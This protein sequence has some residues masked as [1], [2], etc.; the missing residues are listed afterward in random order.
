MKVIVCNKRLH[1]YG[2]MSFAVIFS[3]L[4]DYS[5]GGFNEA[6]PGNWTAI[7]VFIGEG[8]QEAEVFLNINVV[9]QEGAIFYQGR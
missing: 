1:N 6:P 9:N 7:K 2:S 3:A 5:R 8:E 4:G